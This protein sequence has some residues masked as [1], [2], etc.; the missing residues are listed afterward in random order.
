MESFIKKSFIIPA[1]IGSSVGGI[2]GGYISFMQ[3]KNKS[4][5]ENVLKTIT[6]MNFGAVCGGF[7]GIL[8]PITLSVFIG[9]II[10]KEK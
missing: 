5:P 3:T 10:C 7:V 2:C 8:W 1:I 6:G 9:R 4:Y